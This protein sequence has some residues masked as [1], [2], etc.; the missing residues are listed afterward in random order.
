MVLITP[1]IKILPH[2]IGTWSL[3]STNDPQLSNTLTYLEFNYDCTIKLKTIYQDGIIGKKLS[4]S[5]KVT[6][7][8]SRNTSFSSIDIKYNTY[9]TYSLSVCGIKIPE[10]KSEPIIKNKALIKKLR[11]DYYD[12]TIIINNDRLNTFYIFDLCT[13]KPE[14]PFIETYLNTFLFTQLVSFFLNLIL[15]KVLHNLFYI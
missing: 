7:I 13:Q 3:R 10:I 15:A 9:T 6:L 14:F 2:L 8:D 5:G 12:K 11:V 1:V 4:R